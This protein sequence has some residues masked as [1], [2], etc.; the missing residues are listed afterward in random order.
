MIMLH[1][2]G[3]AG[4]QVDLKFVTVAETPVPFC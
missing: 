2:G 1:R 4:I 3:F